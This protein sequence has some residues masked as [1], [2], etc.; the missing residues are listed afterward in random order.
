MI[1]SYL[2]FLQ[3]LMCQFMSNVPDHQLFVGGRVHTLLIEQGCLPEGD[4]T[5]VLHG[6]HIEVGYGKEI[7]QAA[8]NG[9]A[10]AR[11]RG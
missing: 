8:I 2:H 11:E 3:Y 10:R 1:T 9:S 6:T 5:P 7:W 4:Q